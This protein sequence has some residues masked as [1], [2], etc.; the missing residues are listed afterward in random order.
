[1]CSR[2]QRGTEISCSLGSD[3]S[4]IDH[5]DD[6]LEQAIGCAGP[7][8]R[9]HPGL[10]CQGR[11]HEA[12]ASSRG[13]VEEA[14]HHGDD[15]HFHGNGSDIVSNPVEWSPASSERRGGGQTRGG[16]GQ[17]R[18]RLRRTRTQSLFRNVLRPVKNK[19]SVELIIHFAL[20]MSTLLYVIFL[21]GASLH[22]HTEGIRKP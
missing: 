9:P 4:Y 1:M 10:G 12:P 14:Q 11:P 5:I 17:R 22:I 3:T 2:A 18:P 21:A 15:K 19:F 7:D 16:E 8:L 13:E 20:A 6:H